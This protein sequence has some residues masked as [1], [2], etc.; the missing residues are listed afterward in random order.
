MGKPLRE[1]KVTAKALSLGG[2]LLTATATEL[3]TLSGFTGTA[4]ALNK[5][6]AMTGY[7]MEA[8]EVTFTE[9][10]QAHR[11]CCRDGYSYP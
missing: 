10:S 6:N 11:H 9:T 5:T 3:N 7:P 8:A 4:A 2:T 1:N